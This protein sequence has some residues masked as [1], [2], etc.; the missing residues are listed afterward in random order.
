MR[1]QE[2]RRRGREKTNCTVLLGRVR[3]EEDLKGKWAR[4]RSRGLCTR[5]EGKILV[6]LHYFCTVSF[7]SIILCPF[8]RLFSLSPPCPFPLTHTPLHSSIFSSSLSVTTSDSHHIHFWSSIVKCN[9]N[10]CVLLLRSQCW[11]DHYSSSASN[12]LPLRLL[13]EGDE[14][15]GTSR[16]LPAACPHYLPPQAFFFF[17][18]FW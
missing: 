16:P 1:K 13:R 3:G 18:F 4:G 15:E 14:A 12:P 10:F 17:F 2:E 5:I 6:F 7:P 9:Y 11:K 8:S